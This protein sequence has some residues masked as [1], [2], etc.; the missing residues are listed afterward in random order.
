MGHGFLIFFSSIFFIDI[1]LEAMSV[2]FLE[3]IL[4]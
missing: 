1:F 2:F 4:A 3:D